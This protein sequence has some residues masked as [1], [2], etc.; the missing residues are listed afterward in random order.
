MLLAIFVGFAVV[1]WKIP[2]KIRS[3]RQPFKSKNEKPQRGP[4]SVK[5]GSLALTRSRG[6]CW[7]IGMAD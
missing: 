3:R 6:G 7:P 5:N 2:K 4:P 1:E